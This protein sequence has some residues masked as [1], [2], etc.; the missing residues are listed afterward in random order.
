MQRYKMLL[1]ILKYEC[2]ICFS[3]CLMTN[4]SMNTKKSEQ[5]GKIQNIEA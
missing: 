1:L 4:T 5:S 2:A 3:M